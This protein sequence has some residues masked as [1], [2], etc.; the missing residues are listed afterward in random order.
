MTGRDRFLESTAEED[1]AAEEA[2]R[3]EEER[4]YQEHLDEMWGLWNE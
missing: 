1:R 3:E 2:Q 4:L